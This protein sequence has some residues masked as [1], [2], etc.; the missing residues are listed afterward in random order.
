M[1]ECTQAAG[2]PGAVKLC[3]PGLSS[4]LGIAQRGMS[5]RPRCPVFVFILEPQHAQHL[6][7]CRCLMH[8]CLLF[9]LCSLQLPGHC[10]FQTL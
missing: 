3:Q 10:T 2:G 1:L 5:L 6:G 4:R 9:V 7:H 8:A